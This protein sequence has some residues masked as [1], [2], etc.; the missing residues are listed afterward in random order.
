MMSRIDLSPSISCV[1]PAYNEARNLVTV[2]PR[3]LA[4]LSSLSD[5]VELIVIDDGS[6]DDTKIGRASC[7]E[8][9]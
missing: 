9:V 8:R 3:I 2:V 7:R 1:V 5:R 4:T 6:R